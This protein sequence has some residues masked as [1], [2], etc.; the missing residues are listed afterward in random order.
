MEPTIKAILARFNG[1]KYEA[2]AY[3]MRTLHGCNNPSLAKE[4]FDIAVK[5]FHPLSERKSCS[6]R[7]N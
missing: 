7:T 6:L 1:N 2:Y 5:N 4:Y 3:C